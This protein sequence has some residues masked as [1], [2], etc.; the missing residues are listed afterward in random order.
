[1]A[2]L[3]YLS[4]KIAHR[5]KQGATIGGYA[6]SAYG[7]ISPPVMSCSTDAPYTK[8]TS[9]IVALPFNVNDFIGMGSLEFNGDTIFEKETM[10][11]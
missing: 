9:I 2:L 11:F 5:D 6:S 10:I 1:M 8:S 7:E 3:L 4:L